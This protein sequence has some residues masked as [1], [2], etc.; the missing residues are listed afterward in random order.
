MKVDVEIERT[1]KSLD[2]GYCTSLCHGLCITCFSG[3]MG[4][5][6]AVNDT[7]NFTH[8]GWLTGK[9]KAQWKWNAN[10]HMDVGGRAM[11]GAIADQEDDHSLT[12]FD[13]SINGK[14]DRFVFRFVRKLDPT[15]FP[16]RNIE[17]G[18]GS[19]EYFGRHGNRF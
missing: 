1:T 6:G 8:N 14:T 11:P 10:D 7:Q 18:N 5:N 2:Q 4:G 16:F 9:Q 17:I 13:P 19:F 3:Q 15:L 12:V